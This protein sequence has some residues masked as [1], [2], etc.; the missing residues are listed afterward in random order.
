MSLRNELWMWFRYRVLRRLVLNQ[1]GYWVSCGQTG[2]DMVIRAI[3]NDVDRG[4]YVDIGAYHPVGFSNTYHFYLRGWRGLNVDA[5]PDA[6]QLFNRLRPRDINVQACVDEKA[7]VEKDFHIFDRPAL[8]TITE[9]GLKAGL[10][11][12]GAK[13]EKTIRLVTRSVNDLLAEHV[14]ADQPIHFLTMDVEGLDNALLQSLDF[15]RY[16][17]WVICFEDREASANRETP[18]IRMMKDRGYAVA[19]LTPLSVIMKKENL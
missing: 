17:P 12:H 18:A 10:V 9:A 11:T 15:N 5:S 14:P 19:G 4:F 8:N 1:S 16:R 7:G 2:E 13:L 6:M 3:L